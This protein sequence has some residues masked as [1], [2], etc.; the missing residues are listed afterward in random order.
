MTTGSLPAPG[1]G[2]VD[3]PPVG[4]G[5]QSVPVR[6]GWIEAGWSALVVALGAAALA[7]AWD[8]WLATVVLGGTA[9]LGVLLVAVG[10]ALRLSVLVVTLAVLAGL[11]VVTTALLR[12]GA[13]PADTRPWQLL[14]DA[15]PRL[16]TGPRPAPVVADL[17]A[18]GVLLTGLVAVLVGVR[19]GRGRR[20]R[21]SPL[22]GAL[23]LYVAGIALSAGAVDR[24]GLL[25]VGIVV[26]AVAGWSSVDG[27]GGG[28]R[29]MVRGRLVAA[30]ALAAVAVPLVAAGALL[31]R[32]D[33]FDPR[34]VV[35]PPATEVV[36][37]NPMPQLDAWARDP[38]RELFA[39]SGDVFPLHLAV[40][41]EYDG[42][43]WAAPSAFR[44]LGEAE[45]A[46][47]P[48]DR[49]A[50]VASRVT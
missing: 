28:D 17:L 25:A 44:P 36:V 40:L 3:H 39:V 47:G 31:D 9:V 38:E 21:T 6:P 37:A 33:A 41:T 5:T 34:T 1:A 30:G 20:H 19:S 43:A 45:P 16:V 29:S 8:G 2:P 22:V 23:V 35:E 42:S 13:T 10:R 50:R 26:L 49:Q 11:V 14:A 18:P 48:G 12:S 24:W 32:D 27:G 7:A 15:V 46:L 4:P